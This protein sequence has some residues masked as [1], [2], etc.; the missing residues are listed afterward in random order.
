MKDMIDTGLDIRSFTKID[1]Y[2][3][4]VAVAAEKDRTTANSPAIAKLMKSE[5][6]RKGIFQMTKVCIT[7]IDLFCLCDIDI[8]SGADTKNGGGLTNYMQQVTS[9]YP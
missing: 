7:I 2:K 9:K 4:E 5:T 6:V 3:T 1:K 8:F